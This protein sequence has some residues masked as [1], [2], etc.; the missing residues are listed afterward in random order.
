[1]V[2]LQVLTLCL[3]P[4]VN[5][6]LKTRASTIAVTYNVDFRQLHSMRMLPPLPWRH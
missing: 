6:A 3:G 1:M 2:G 4:H 5:T